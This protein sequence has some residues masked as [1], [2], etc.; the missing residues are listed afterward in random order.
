MLHSAY[1]VHA[2]AGDRIIGKRKIMSI[3]VGRIGKEVRGRMC[4]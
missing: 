2:E 4:V 1:K 3:E